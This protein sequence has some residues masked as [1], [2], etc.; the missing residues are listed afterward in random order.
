MLKRGNEATH[1]QKETVMRNINRVS[2]YLL[3]TVAMLA[4][5]FTA[6]AYEVQVLTGDG[7]ESKMMDKGKY[8]VAIKRLERRT[9]HDS[10]TIDIQLTNLCTAYVVTG[11]FDKARETCNRAVEKKGDFVGTAYNSRGV[12]NALTGDYIAANADFE[13]AENKA[14]YPVARTDFGDMAPSRDRF[15]T[16]QDKIEDSMKLAAQ[17]HQFADQRW[18]ALREEAEELTA[19]VK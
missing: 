14:N 7:S 13:Q 17:N 8:D 9:Q 5:S 16:Q 6:S 2:K 3:A 18:A 19:G 15:G 11:E 4:I 12:L 10:P 1:L